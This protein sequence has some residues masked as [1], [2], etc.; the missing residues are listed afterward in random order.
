[1]YICISNFDPQFKSRM[2]ITVIKI[3]VYKIK[4]ISSSFATNRHFQCINIECYN[5]NKNP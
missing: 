5:N 1:M 2:R 3:S 4:N